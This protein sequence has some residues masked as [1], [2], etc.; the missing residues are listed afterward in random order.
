MASTADDYNI[1]GWLWRGIAPSWTP[2]GVSA[3]PLPQ[4]GE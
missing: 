3:Q 2:T 4:Q 1:V